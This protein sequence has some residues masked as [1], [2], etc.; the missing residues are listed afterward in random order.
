MFC[1]YQSIL[2][3]SRNTFFQVGGLRIVQIPALVALILCIVGATSASNPTQ[4]ESEETVHIGIILFLLV[5]IILVIMTIIAV[6]CIKKVPEQE[7]VLVKA[8]VL[9]LPFMFVHILYSLLVTFSH[10]SDFNLVYGSKTIFLCMSVIEEMVIVLLYIFAGLRVKSTPLPQDASPARTT[11][12]RAGRGDN[13]GGRLGLVSLGFGA[14]NAVGNRGD[15]N[16]RRQ[17][18]SDSGV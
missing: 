1:S 9:S 3:Q 16:S 7:W 10:N 15:K 18:S 2:A 5:F 13:G 17:Q 6:I 14:A 11:G 12:Y 8:V 4:I